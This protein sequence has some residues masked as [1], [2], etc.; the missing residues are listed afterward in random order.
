MRSSVPA[1][2]K[3]CAVGPHFCYCRSTLT[4][5]RDVIR[6]N[7]VHIENTG[8][9]SAL[10]EISPLPGA[11]SRNWISH[12]NQGYPHSR[13]RPGTPAGNRHRQ[14][15]CIA[16]ASKAEREPQKCL[17]GAGF[18]MNVRSKELPL[19]G[20]FTFRGPHPFFVRFDV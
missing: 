17:F 6:K 1:I 2:A 20:R 5:E 4:T 9:R 18:A 3:I 14:I 15:E 7:Y 13:L 19:S 10:R 12:Y 16:I 11:P 8:F